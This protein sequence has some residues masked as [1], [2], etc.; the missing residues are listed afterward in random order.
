LASRWL[1]LSGE[2]EGRVGVNVLFGKY[3]L[4]P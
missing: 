2:A 4:E 3:G 1:G